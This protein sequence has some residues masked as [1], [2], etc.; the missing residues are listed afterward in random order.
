M[1]GG[2]KVK[3]LASTLHVVFSNFS[4]VTAPMVIFHKFSGALLPDSHPNAAPPLYITPLQN[5]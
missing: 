3:E 1:E 4:S 5:P 2:G